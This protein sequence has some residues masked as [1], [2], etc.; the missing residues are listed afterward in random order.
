VLIDLFFIDRAFLTE[1]VEE[2]YANT[3]GR[4]L[5]ASTAIKILGPMNMTA[6]QLFANMGKKISSTPGKNFSVPESF[7]AGATL[8]R[9][10]VT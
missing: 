9:C 4:Y 2:Q 7:D 6:C 10:L 8:Q 3:V 1:E 5:S